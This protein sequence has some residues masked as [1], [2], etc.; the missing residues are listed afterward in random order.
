MSLIPADPPKSSAP[1]LPTP[2]FLGLTVV[3]GVL[4]L[5]VRTIDLGSIPPGLHFDQAANGLLGLEILSG[6]AHPVFFSSYTGREA[7]FFYLIAALEAVLGPS[8]VAI[9]LAGALAGTATVVAV[10]FLGAKLFN[11]RVGLAAGALL[12]GLYWDIQVS[13]LGERTSLVPLLDTLALLALW[14]AF[15][16]RSL[17]L[18]CLGG[19]LVGL[20]LYTYPSSRFFLFVLGLIGLSE[21]I[22]VAEGA[23]RG[24]RVPV[25]H[26]STAPS[27][28][29]LAVLT[30]GAVVVGVLVVV[31]LALHFYHHPADF[32][33]RAD[34]VAIW[35][36]VVAGAS[37]MNVLATSTQHTLAMFVLLGDRDWKYNLAGRPVFDPISAVF[38]LIG[39]ALA[40]W[41]WRRRAERICLLWWLGMLVPGFLSVDSPQFMRTLG[42]APAAVLFAANGLSAII[43]WLES[44]PLP[45]R[46][47]GNGG[48]GLS[49]FSP[50][51]GEG[52]RGR[53]VR[54]LASL[55][56]LWPL[57]AGAFAAYQY[58]AVW[59]PS[60]AA[61]LALEGD[62]TAAA[63]IIQARAEQYPATYV[64]SRYGPDPT[65]AFLDGDV[66]SRLHWFDGRSAL[67]LP[68]PGA[69]PTLYVLPRT[70]TDGWWYDRLPASDR[71]S[72][73]LAPDHGPAVEAFVLRPDS[74]KPDDKSAIPPV[75]V[76]GVAHLV[77][78]D[79]P[80]A[81]QAGLPAAPAFY[82]QIER[83]PAE[84]VKFF[85]HL[86]DSAGQT[87]AQYDEDVY[88]TSEWRS[89]QLLIVRRSFPVPSY[90]PLGTY[91]LQVGIER[92][93]GTALPVQTPGQ[94]TATYWQSRTIQVARPS[95]PPDPATLPIAQHFD[96]SFGGTLRLIGATISPGKV[97]DGDSVG[98]SLVWQ[99]IRTPTGSLDTV[100][101]ANN[102]VDQPLARGRRPP[103]GGVWSP[104]YWQPGDVIVDRQTLLIPAGTVPG[105]LSLLVGVDEANQQALPLVGNASGLTPIGTLVVQARPRSTETVAIPHRQD[106]AFV[107]GIHLLGYAVQPATA[108]P[109]QSIQL[110]LY[111]QTTRPISQSFTVFSHVLDAKNQVV[112]QHDGIP[113]DAQRPTTTWAPGETLV[114]RHVLVVQAN[115]PIGASQ[116]EIGLYDA[117]TGQR[118]KT[119]DGADRVLLSD[120]VVI[121]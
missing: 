81:I 51:G 95:A 76:G 13:R 2:L 22:A 109:G 92:Q 73:V 112:A 43:R 16:R 36:P 115:A 77:G 11:R 26:A 14:E 85:V 72:E 8:V 64:A 34:E 98:I 55:L 90:A 97:L 111:W 86:I 18:A 37:P 21:L 60:A 100:L 82:W 20:Q 61:Y 1:D 44:L 12:A 25:R 119:S 79:V 116:L 83:P 15:R 56:W 67:P 58:F 106:V 27:F 114:D 69:G 105:T 41:R 117:K 45:H 7:L 71:V 108:G 3:I 40:V 110:T 78:A 118:L 5:L 35:N 96:M 101:Q 38:F 54:P 75:D 9:R 29:H 120:S 62:V 121:H 63:G 68:P 24:A 33:G 113:V 74:L 99:V 52:A 103:T 49:P 23:R 42:A 87:W 50:R 46:R 84:P 59:A 104:R 39:L 6:Q 17:P 94:P 88:P 31:P 4:A 28:G 65:I 91:I 48:E 66:F 107:N 93:D 19:G 80:P 57:F 30:L 89:G 102:A 70:A 32:L 47:R 53:E 10:I